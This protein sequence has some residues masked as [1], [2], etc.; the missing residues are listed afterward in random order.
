MIARLV[1]HD[2]MT[3]EYYSRIFESNNLENS[4]VSMRRRVTVSARRLVFYILKKHSAHDNTLSRG[5][6]LQPHV[7]SGVVAPML[8]SSRA[9]V[10]E[11]IRQSV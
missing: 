11:L 2:S 7:S 4:H 1:G 5:H 10:V 3:S 6:V 8:M 9:A